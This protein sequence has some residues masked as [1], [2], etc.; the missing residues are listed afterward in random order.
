M[1]TQESA[2]RRNRCLRK[3]RL[4]RRVPLEIKA[5]LGVLV[6][7]LSPSTRHELAWPSASTIAARIG[8]TVRTVRWHLK[9]IRRTG[10]FNFQRFSP[11]DAAAFCESRYGFSPRFDRCSRQAPTLYRVNAAH[12][13]WSDATKVT[14]EQDE[15]L[16]TTLASVL[17]DRNRH[18]NRDT[19]AA[20]TSRRL[21]GASG[22]VKRNHTRHDLDGYRSRFAE[23]IG[24]LESIEIHGLEVN[25]DD[26]V[27][28]ILGH[29]VDDIP[30]DDVRFTQ[31]CELQ[32]V[33]Q[34][35]GSSLGS[36]L[37]H[38]TPLGCAQ[39]FQPSVACP[40]LAVAGPTASSEP[41]PLDGSGPGGPSPSS[42]MGPVFSDFGKSLQ[43]GGMKRLQS[44][45][46]PEQELEDLDAGEFLEYSGLLQ[47]F[48]QE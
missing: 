36:L 19:P 10:I 30:M 24:R 4:C 32:E 44:L 2:A 38:P 28:D 8:R 42:A 12:W 26:V 31:V 20:S 47:A 23:I 48:L 46:L 18:K 27:D 14:P 3:I 29:D 11:M 5:T 15:E 45:L 35:V 39:T 13:L 9:A 33:R 41:I 17:V 6:D 34:G 40:V 7:H 25:A 43:G 1:S 37:S 21:S 22:I 16:G